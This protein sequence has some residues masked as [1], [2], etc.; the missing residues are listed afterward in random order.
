MNG[1]FFAGHRIE[2]TLYS[3]R[4]RFR[5]SGAA[6]DIDVDGDEAEKR[7]LD[8]FAKWLMTEGD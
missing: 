4:Q 6:E 5:R 7:R 3:G 1:R 2:A 8:D